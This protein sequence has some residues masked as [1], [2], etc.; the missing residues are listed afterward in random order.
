MK[1]L[2]NMTIEEIEKLFGAGSLIPIGDVTS[3]RWQCG[4]CEQV[5]HAETPIGHPAPCACGSVLFVKL[6]NSLH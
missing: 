4:R 6:P 2:E 1:R 5:V 3:R